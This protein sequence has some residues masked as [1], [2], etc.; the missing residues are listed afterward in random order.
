MIPKECQRKLYIQKNFLY[1]SPFRVNFVEF[2][3]K[4]VAE[5][6]CD[7][8]AVFC[9]VFPKICGDVLWAYAFCALLCAS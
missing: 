1:E 9:D 2:A 4:S 8:V 6:G 7:T 3:Q 5:H